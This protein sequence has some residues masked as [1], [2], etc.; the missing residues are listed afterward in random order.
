MKPSVAFLV[1]NF[2][3]LSA[4][5]IINQI[6]GFINR[7]WKVRIFAL[8]DPG[9]LQIHKDVSRYGLIEKTTYFAI[10][11]RKFNRIFKA[12]KF[13]AGNIF[14]RPGRVLKSFTP[15]Y[16]PGETLRLNTP[17]YLK[18]FLDEDFDVLFCHF[19]PNGLLGALLKGL[20]V[21]GRLV[22]VFHG[23]DLSSYLRNHRQGVYKRLFSDGDLFMPVSRH[24]KEKL[25]EL[26]CSEDRIT[27]HH[28]GI[29]VNRFQPVEDKA[30]VLQRLELLTVGRL[31]EKKGH[32]SVIKAL[33]DFSCKE[34]WRYTIA[35][36]GPLLPWLERLAA[37]LGVQEK[38]R[39]TGPLKEK[40]ILPL[41][42]D[43]HIFLL[44]SVT[45]PDG[46]CEGIPM[47]LM[48][49]MAM[50]LPIIST[51]HSGIPELVEDGKSGFLV[52]ENDSAGIKAYLIKL[53]SDESLRRH[54]GVAGRAKVEREFNLHV[55]N[56][57]LAKI[58][59]KLVE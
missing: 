30:E 49:A 48:E 46:D 10:P 32:A 22:T 58:I 11:K 19:G 29:D 20:K 14:R 35:G 5:F 47:V 28:L 42:R 57:T 13:L 18:P 45:G 33:R 16:F 51:W 17:F 54:M 52:E 43:S 23:H 6:I 25:I 39:F 9:E 12:V 55:Q 7:G 31:V 40:E 50:Q 41:Y 27:V 59:M 44:P 53:A 36:D 4:T 21:P 15:W 56:D 26:G 8:R 37:E 38:I 3:A 1:G 2:P 34:D 24:W